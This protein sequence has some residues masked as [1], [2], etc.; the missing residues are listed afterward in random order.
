MCAECA[1]LQELLREQ[2]ACVEAAQ[3][4]AEAVGAAADAGAAAQLQAAPAG[5]D[6][7]AAPGRV[8]VA[9]ERWRQGVDARE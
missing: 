6:P 9:Y 4:S 3:R 7:L 8:R 1:R 5:G 2:L